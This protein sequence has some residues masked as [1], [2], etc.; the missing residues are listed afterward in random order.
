VSEVA[1]LR[2]ELLAARNRA[3]RRRNLERCGHLLDYCRRARM[4]PWQRF[5]RDTEG[6]LAGRI[7][8]WQ[9]ARSWRRV[10]AGGELGRPRTYSD[11]RHARWAAKQRRRYASRP[12]VKARRAGK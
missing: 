6:L 7:P 11:E 8:F 4:H 3:T 2:L 10:L 5:V 12:E 9:W 1:E